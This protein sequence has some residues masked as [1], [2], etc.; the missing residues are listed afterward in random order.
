MRFC[1]VC[2]LFLLNTK[3]LFIL[4]NTTDFK[5]VAKTFSGLEELLAEELKNLGASNIEKGT[6]VVTFYGDQAMMYRANYQLRTAISVLK[7][8]AEFTANNEDDLYK[9]VGRISWSKYMDLNETFSVSAVTF[10][11]IFKH[12]KYASLKVKDAVVDQFRRRQGKRPNVDT[13]NPDLKIHLHV[14]ENKCTLLIDSSGEP[15]FK[16][17]YRKQAVKAPINEVL[18]A[19]MVKLSGWD[20]Q[21]D[22]YD[23]MCGSG[24]ILIEAALMA[25]N[26]PPGTF[27]KKFG[28][29]SWKD[30]DEDLF[31]DIAE[32]QFGDIDF[33]HKII[34]SDISPISVKIAKE[35]IKEAF[36]HK[37]IDVKPQNFF[38]TKTPPKGSYVITNPPYGER[39]Q[40]DDLK[41]FYQKI[42]DKLKIDYKSCKVWLIGSN[43]D[44]IKFIGLKPNKKITL[45]NGALE[46]SYRCF[47]M[48]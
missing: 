25:Y 43:L 11:E 17:G 3:H 19:A 5:M 21:S 16:R 9:E 10:S 39:L 27:R 38:D 12:S 36:L 34:G 4:N 33:K 1:Y 18:A 32:E 23:P 41:I 35:N 46:C 20:M 48:Y 47:D 26:I 37:K 8:I 42:G 15:L 6:R 13:S 14:S 7:P 40:P 22:L 31:Q 2:T 45:Y 28:F 30:F 24:T 29:E 44:V